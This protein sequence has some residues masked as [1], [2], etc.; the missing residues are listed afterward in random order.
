M[1]KFSKEFQWRNKTISLVINNLIFK[2][3]LNKIKIQT[4]LLLR[5]FF[6]IYATIAKVF[7]NNPQKLHNLMI[8]NLI[9]SLIF[10]ETEKYSL[11]GFL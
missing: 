1:Q 7:R 10:Y 3:E 11:F 5:L 2:V 6:F 9:N 8:N 4:V